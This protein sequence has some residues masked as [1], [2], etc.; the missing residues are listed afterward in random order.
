MIILIVPR[1][2]LG[3]TGGSVRLSGV[4]GQKGPFD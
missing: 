3:G 4:R 2:G 1:V